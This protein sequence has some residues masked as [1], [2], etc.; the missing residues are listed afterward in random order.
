MNRPVQLAGISR[1]EA[2]I[3][4]RLHLGK[5][6]QGKYRGV[7]MFVSLKFLLFHV[8]RWVVRLRYHD[9]VVFLARLKLMVGNKSSIVSIES[10]SVKHESRNYAIFLIYQPNGISWYVENALDSLREAAI[11]VVAVVNHKVDAEQLRYL[12]ERSKLI[13]IRNN[14]GFDMGGFRD[15]TLYLNSL[16]IDVERLIYINDSIYFFKAGLTGL[17][18]RLADS[19]SD[20]CALFEN[21]EIHYHIQSFCFSISGRIFRN[22]KFQKFWENYLPV[23]SRLWA[24]NKGEVGLSRTIVPLAEAIDIIYRPNNLRDCLNEVEDLDSRMTLARRIP[25]PIRDQSS[26][27]CTMTNTEA[28]QIF[29][30][31]IGSGSQIHTGGFIYMKYKNFPLMKRDLLFRDQFTVDEIEEA[32]MEVDHEGHFNEIMTDF[33]KKGRASQL[34]ILKRLQAASGII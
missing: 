26:E 25:I 16:G 32:L 13:V 9:A 34:P 20:I 5:L 12:K 15:S 1:I 28:A 6:P 27:F 14:A 19:Q 7:T 2:E 33:R 11:N 3:K 23:N 18:S 8:A 30:S 29:I 22:V 4:K 17:F 10:G 24:I 31:K 21:W